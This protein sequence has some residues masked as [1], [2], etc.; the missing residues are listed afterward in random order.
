[1]AISGFTEPELLGQP[2]SMIRHPDMPRAVFKLLWDRLGAGHEIFAYVKNMTKSGD[3]YWVHA[4]VTQSISTAIEQQGAA[5]GNRDAGCSAQCDR[6]A[7]G[8]LGNRRHF[9]PSARRIRPVVE[10]GRTASQSDRVVHQR[11]HRQVADLTTR[12]ASENS[13]P[14]VHAGAVF[15][16]LAVTTT[17]HKGDGDRP[18]RMFSPR[19]AG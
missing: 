18:C 9:Q 4:H 11:H 13:G 1:M 8:G 6:D 15:V 3:Y 12:L 19:P 16:S 10:G 5:G 14:G 17:G 2:H 7:A